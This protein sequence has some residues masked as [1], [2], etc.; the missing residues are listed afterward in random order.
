MIQ[1]DGLFNFR[2]HE[3]V[4]DSNGEVDLLS[5]FDGMEKAAKYELWRRYSVC[6]CYVCGILKLAC[7]SLRGMENHLREQ[8]EAYESRVETLEFKNEHL[9]KENEQLQALFQEKSDVNHSIA[10]EVARLAAD[11]MVRKSACSW[12]HLCLESEGQRMC[13]FVSTGDSRTKAAGV[14]TDP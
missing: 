1:I 8:K 12:V 3:E 6:L 5:A 10:Q 11:N 7:F 14:G 4:S 9:T 13:R 2:L